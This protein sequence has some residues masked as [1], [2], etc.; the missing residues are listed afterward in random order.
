MS[1]IFL[2]LKQR[3][4]LAL[5]AGA[6]VVSAQTS[7][8]QG[9]QAVSKVAVPTEELLAQFP[10]LTGFRLSPDARHLLAIESRGDQ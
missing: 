5:L 3:L 9:Q 10:S 6:S 4:V 8:P 7:P 1:R 2:R